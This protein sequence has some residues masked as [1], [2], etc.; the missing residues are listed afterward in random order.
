LFIILKNL[1][2]SFFIIILVQT[3]RPQSC[4]SFLFKKTTDVSVD[5]ICNDLLINDLQ[6]IKQKIE[7]I[8]PAPFLYCTKS[9]FDSAYNA[10]LLALNQPH[11]LID[12]S[13]LVSD[14][15]SLLRDSHTFLPPTNLSQYKRNGRD[16]YPIRLCESN[17]KLLVTKCWKNRIP[18]GAELI[19]FNGLSLSRA[20]DVSLRLS[21]IEADAFQAQ[22]EFSIGQ[23]GEILNYCSI[24]PERTITYCLPNKDTITKNFVLPLLFRSK[25]TRRFNAPKKELNLTL[26]NSTAHLTI[27]SFSPF[28]YRKFNLEL[29]KLFNQIKAKGIN[30]LIIDLRNNF[31]GYVALQEYLMLLIAKNDQPYKAEYVYKR[32]RYDRFSN[33]NFQQQ[34]RFKQLATRSYSSDALRKEL[35]FFYS[36]Y[37]TID[38][39]LITTQLKNKSIEPYTGKCTLLINGLSM[40]AAANFA[41]W[42]RG[43]KRGEIIGT[44]CMGSSSGTFANSARLILPNTLLS[45]SISTLKITPLHV[46]DGPTNQIEL[47]RK[48][49]ATQSQ[50]I[51]AIDPCIYYLLNQ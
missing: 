10:A 13:L 5:K 36:P 41:A 39:I 6:F 49:T 2:A 24:G 23:L 1:F 33:L 11:S 16:N 43:A 50:L 47:D 29:T 44:Q 22:M 7:E 4:K 14:W 20:K 27:N 8:H 34:W 17:E 15:L 48:I 35:A 9:V 3:A 18:V 46:D 26:Y 51:N 30:H 37:G 32:S 38:T 21:P 25:S 45:I 42:F 12:F 19:A 40:S 31:G 28:S